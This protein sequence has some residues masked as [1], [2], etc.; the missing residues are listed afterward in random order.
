VI[1]SKLAVIT[2]IDT[3]RSE[4]AERLLDRLGREGHALLA[5][6]LWRYEVTSTI[7]KYR[8]D[9]LIDRDRV[10][11]TLSTALS[12][13][14][15]IDEDTALCQSALIW[16]ERLGQRA[17]YDGFYLAL[18]ERL[19]AELYTADERLANRA[20]QIGAAWVRGLGAG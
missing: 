1:D 8:A 19:G 11:A 7:N 14:Q 17:A 13:A 16:A 9:K 2:V 18:A 10:A 4:A 20:Q 6:R 3:A 5:P 15:V 12:L